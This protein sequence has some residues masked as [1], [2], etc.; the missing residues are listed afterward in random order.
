MVAAIQVACLLLLNALLRHRGLRKVSV[1]VTEVG[2]DGFELRHI[3]GLRFMTEYVSKETGETV[4]EDEYKGPMELRYTMLGPSDLDF[5]HMEFLRT[6][7]EVDQAFPVTVAK[8]KGKAVVHL[9]ARRW[10]ACEAAFTTKDGVVHRRVLQHHDKCATLLGTRVHMYYSPTRDH[11]FEQPTYAWADDLGRAVEAML[12]I[13]LV[14]RMV[15]LVVR[16]RVAPDSL[17]PPEALN[18]TEYYEAAAAAA[19]AAEATRASVASRLKALASTEFDDRLLRL[20]YEVRGTPRAAQRV[21]RVRF[22]VVVTLLCALPSWF[23][24]QSGHR[25]LSTG[26]RRRWEYWASLTLVTLLFLVYLNS[27]VPMLH[28]ASVRRAVRREQG[29]ALSSLDW[30]RIL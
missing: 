17:L 28:T 6:K 18:G 13:S 14:W 15:K 5:S 7:P 4:D 26:L 1:V 23:F 29:V 21:A 27:Y 9:P 24:F 2:P 20:L 25:T 16:A 19:E 30:A 12:C 8:T 11:F 22:H 10:N 3:D